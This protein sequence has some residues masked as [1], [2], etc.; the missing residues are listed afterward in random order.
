MTGRPI[1]DKGNEQG[2]LKKKKTSEDENEFI[3]RWPKEA[4]NH[5][6][7]NSYKRWYYSLEST[8]T[9]LIQVLAPY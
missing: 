2:S 6:L 7:Q 4:V 3:Y 5:M 1:I 9:V 8:G